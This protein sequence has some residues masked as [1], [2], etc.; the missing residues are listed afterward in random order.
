MKQERYIVFDTETS[1]LSRVDR[2]LEIA[3][4]EFDPAIGKTGRYFHAYINPQK[5]I[6]PHLTAIHGITNQFVANKP[7]F[8]EVA[9]HLIRFI[10]GATLVAH[11]APFDVRFLDSEFERLGLGKLEQYAGG[12]V[13][14][15]A[16]ARRAHPGEKATLDA[17]CD[18]YQVDRSKRDVHGA[19]IDCQL[20]AAVYPPLLIAEQ[21]AAPKPA[22][23]RKKPETPANRPTANPATPVRAGLIQSLCSQVVSWFSIAR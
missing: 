3:A 7:L 1:G 13:C 9:Q 2:I 6:P 22:K 11:N 5:Y 12:I 23:P 21:A 8:A 14:T 10:E 17:L 20:L 4:M 19:L 18:R 15:R 16:M